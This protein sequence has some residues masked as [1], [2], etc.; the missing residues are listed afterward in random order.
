MITDEGC[1]VVPP[2]E[3]SPVKGVSG[4]PT[5][6]KATGDQTGG[7]VAALEQTTPPNSGPPV[8][9]HHESA[10]MFYV[11]EG[12]F[13]FQAGADVFTATRGTF[14]FVPKGIPHTYVNSGAE[15][16]RVLFWFTPPARMVNYFKELAKLPPGPPEGSAL[17]A[18]ADRNGV[19]IVAPPLCVAT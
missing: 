18:I 14:V 3:G 1:V 9:I 8:H 6:I 15:P 13:T 17:Q 19:T 7:L 5:L 10:E 12:E 4:E 16:A 2:G 11:L